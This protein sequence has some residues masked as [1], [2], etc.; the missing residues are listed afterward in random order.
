MKLEQILQD[1][2]PRR[3]RRRVGRGDGSG[4]G[5]TSGRGHKGYL[6]RSGAKRRLGYEG[7]QNPVLARIP[8]RGFN[9]ALFKKSYQ[10]VNLG[11]LEEAFESGANVDPTAM[12]SK[13]LI[14]EATGPVK[15]LGNGSLSKSLTVVAC[16]FSA[17]ASEKIAAAGG[18]IEATEPVDERKQAHREKMQRKID[19][20]R[21]GF[22]EARDKARQ[23]RSEGPQ[24]GK[25]KAKARRAE[26][27]KDSSGGESGKSGKKK[28]DKKKKQ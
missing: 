7:G 18:S 8:K 12:A 27:K 20:A 17:S 21:K 26:G 28:K 19:R 15:V 13:G 1:A 25:A 2:A 24:G 16:R 6:S 11:D 3:R 9:N 23:K 5:K 10:V 22:E 14:S 4:H